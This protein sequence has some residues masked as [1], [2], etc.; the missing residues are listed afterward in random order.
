MRVQKWVF[1]EL[2]GCLHVPNC[3]NSDMNCTKLHLNQRQRNRKKLT[4]VVDIKALNAQ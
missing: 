2:Y 1:F 4:I 3:Q